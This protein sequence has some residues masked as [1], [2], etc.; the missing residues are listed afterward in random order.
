MKDLPHKVFADFFEQRQPG[1]G[2]L[3]RLVL[4]KLEEGHLCLDLSTLQQT[5]SGDYI[6]SA[7]LRPG[8]YVTDN[9]K[10][11][12]PFV[13]YGGNVY[14]QRYFKYESIIVQKIKALV[15][16]EQHAARAA[17]VAVPTFLT[18]RG[19]TDA[20]GVAQPLLHHHGR[21]GHG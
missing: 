18:T 10:E 8:P 9:P 21:A 20:A 11:V 3:A 17:R 5:E 19:T 15:Q 1:L 13:L 7:I 14:F 16:E 6:P 12:K 2:A 4:Q